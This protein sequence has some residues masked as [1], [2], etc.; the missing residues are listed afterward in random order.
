MHKI[1]TEK[2]RQAL[3]Y[4]PPQSRGNS[5]V[6]HRTL[7][8][9]RRHYLPQSPPLPKESCQPAQHRRGPFVV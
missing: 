3:L 7:L 4:P 6:I 2:E 9:L 5:H 1:P 8:L